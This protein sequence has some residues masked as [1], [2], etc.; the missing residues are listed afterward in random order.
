MKKFLFLTIVILLSV[1]P[2]EAQVGINTTSPHQSA[3]LDIE[4]TSKGMLIPRMATIQKTAIVNPAPGLIIYDT[5]L[6]CI[7]QNAGTATSPAW[8]CLSQKDAQNGFFYMPTIAVDAS[9]IVTG[10]T[11]DLYNEYKKQFTAPAKNPSAPA[12]IP[13]FTSRTDLYY[14]ITNYDTDVL[15]NI[16]I[17]NQG[18]MTYD[19]KAESDYDSFMTVV[20][21]LK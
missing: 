17:S 14:Y 12:N 13:Y 5:T 8:V 1:C 2:M 11:I 4:S 16:S 10:K 20:F 19:V 6:R 7:S 21:V 18:V 15:N 3:A 9:T